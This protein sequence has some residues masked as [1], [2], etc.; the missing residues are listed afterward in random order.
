MVSKTEQG[1]ELPFLKYR[2][3]KITCLG[4]KYALLQYIRC[5]KCMPY[6][7]THISICIAQA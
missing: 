2:A 6:S 5:T 4:E 1:H 7:W 3:L